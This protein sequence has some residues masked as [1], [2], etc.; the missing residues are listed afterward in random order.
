MI[1]PDRFQNRVGLLLVSLSIVVAGCGAHEGVR[2]I[3]ELRSAP[4]YT[5][6]ATELDRYL[7]YVSSTHADTIDRAMLFARQSIGQ[8]YR[9]GPLGEF[10]IEISDPD[11]LYCLTN[12]DCV[13]FVE[14]T[15]SMA[16]AHDWPTFM[17]ELTHMRYKGGQ[18]G[19]LTRNHFTEAD[20]NVN[21]A[22]LFEDVTSQIG[23]GAIT[24]YTLRI[25]RKAFFAG[26]GVACD[27]PVQEW[28]DSYIPRKVLP[29]ASSQ[30][31]TGDIIE[32]V[33]GI[34]SPYVGHLGLLSREGDGELMLI[35]STR[36][37]VRREP[38]D[39]YLDA[40]RAFCGFKILRYKAPPASP[41]GSTSR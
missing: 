13:T 14:Q 11:P 23:G 10:P 5:F 4:I 16:L 38:L 25:D 6:D 22:R 27:V 39:G 36:P 19:M 29:E 35:H 8:P 3:V 24:S 32:F 34:K 15:W 7:R 33:R 1:L 40:H 41:A 20:W 21:N 12:S 37:A 9:L 17:N 30:L 26:K 31:R 28:A 2:G 18:I